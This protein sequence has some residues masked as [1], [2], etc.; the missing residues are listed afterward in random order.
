MGKNYATITLKDIAEHFN[1]TEYYL[2][3][4]IKTHTGQNAS[5][6]LIE[7]RLSKACELLVETNSY[8]E[9]IA[10]KVGYKSSGYFYN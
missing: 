7:M 4:F 2:T 10:Y 1:Y 8:V 3:K 6:L 5:R 9:E